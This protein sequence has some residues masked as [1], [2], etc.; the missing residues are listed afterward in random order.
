[1]SDEKVDT[2]VAVERRKQFDD[3]VSAYRNKVFAVVF[4]KTHDPELSNEVSQEAITKY[5]TAREKEHWQSEIENEEAYIVQIALNLLN[6][7]WR[8]DGK[9]EWM[10]IDQQLDDRL[11]NA[12]SKTTSGVDVE[13][14]IYWQKLAQVLPWKTIFIGLN[15]RET[16]I[17]L[18]HA[19][20][21]LSNEEIALELNENV[22]FIRYELTKVKAK[23][24]ARVKKI[25]GKNKW[26]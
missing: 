9:A 12:L 22:V 7:K 10:S 21:G 20:E 15:E 5:L 16:S 13:N 3:N 2:K 11:L 19:V 26:I 18:L 25:C 17:F 1:M 23:I 6:D 24:R 8:G 4:N 14:K